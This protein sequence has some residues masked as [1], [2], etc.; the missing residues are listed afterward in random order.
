MQYTR[1]RPKR[2]PCEDGVLPVIKV[3]TKEQGV[4]THRISRLTTVSWKDKEGKERWLQ[5]LSLQGSHKRQS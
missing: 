5:F 1:K 2:Q 4:E 3:V